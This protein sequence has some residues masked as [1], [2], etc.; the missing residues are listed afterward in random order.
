MDIK[1]ANNAAIVM[2]F[3]LGR[4]FDHC[5][6]MVARVTDPRQFDVDRFLRFMKSTQLYD[7]ISIDVINSVGMQMSAGIPQGMG[8][9][10]R[11][12]NPYAFG[13]FQIAQGILIDDSNISSWA[14]LYKQLHA[15]IKSYGDIEN[16]IWFFQK[17]SLEA[18]L[19]SQPAMFH[20]VIL[21]QDDIIYP[22]W[23]EVQ[24]PVMYAGANPTD[25][26]GQ[27]INKNAW[28]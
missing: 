7:T 23:F 18:Y 8:A 24:N 11:V 17:Q 2:S 22:A 15:A 21:G 19:H 26:N 6:Y 4:D 5:F 25:L 28:G 13:Q 9:G 12:N 16:V 10:M 20:Q 1:D 27:P 3:N 14:D